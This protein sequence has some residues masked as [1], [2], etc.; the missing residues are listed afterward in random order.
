MTLARRAIADIRE[1]GIQCVQV[2]FSE[3]LTR[4]YE[5]CGFYILGGG[6]IDFEH[7]EWTE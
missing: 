3:G 7:M 2:T 5:Q 6:I 1:A 4:F